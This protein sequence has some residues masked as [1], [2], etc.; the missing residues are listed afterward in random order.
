[1][2][3]TTSVQME[4]FA[5]FRVIASSGV[6]GSINEERAEVRRGRSAEMQAGSLAQVWAGIVRPMSTKVLGPESVT[7]H[8][9]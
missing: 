7:V 1:M 2:C 6:S 5:D 8:R 9:G 3:L 4:P